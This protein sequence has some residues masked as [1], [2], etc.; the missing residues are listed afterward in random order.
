MPTYL[1]TLH[2]PN[3]RTYECV[4]ASEARLVLGQEFE[5]F[6]HIWRIVRPSPRAARPT[7]GWAP[8]PE[9]Y[10]CHPVTANLT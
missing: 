6:G 4:E 5:R 8:P 3:G 9:A 2:Y 7:N 1:L 10:D